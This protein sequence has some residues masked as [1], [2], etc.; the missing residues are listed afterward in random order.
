MALHFAYRLL[1]AKGLFC[2]RTPRQTID[3][4]MRWQ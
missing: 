4:L 3:H 2:E 1:G